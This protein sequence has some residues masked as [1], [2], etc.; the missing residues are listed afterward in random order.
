MKE[1]YKNEKVPIA[2]LALEARV[3][4]FLRMLARSGHPVHLNLSQLGLK[5]EGVVRRRE[6]LN[7]FSCPEVFDFS[8]LRLSMSLTA[9]SLIRSD[10]CFRPVVPGVFRLVSD[11]SAEVETVSVSGG[12][13][14][15]PQGK[16]LR[17]SLSDIRVVP[18]YMVKLLPDIVR[19][20]RS[21]LDGACQRGLDVSLDASASRS[22]TADGMIRR[23]GLEGEYTYVVGYTEFTAEEFVMEDMSIGFGAEDD[24][25]VPVLRGERVLAVCGGGRVD[26]TERIAESALDDVRF[27]E[28]CCGKTLTFMRRAGDDGLHSLVLAEG[29][30]AVLT[31]PPCRLEELASVVG[32]CQDRNTTKGCRT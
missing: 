19:S 20:A 28:P 29:P 26:T 15:D 21:I 16:A 31:V 11:A 25:D 10:A 27:G 7:E 6:T 14:F 2:R 17:A 30:G 22:E 12:G 1:E 5:A 8:G 3:A 32:D 9:G 23:Y 18:A 13:I 24:D 4:K